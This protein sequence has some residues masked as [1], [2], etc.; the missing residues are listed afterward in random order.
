[1]TKIDDD[2]EMLF[3]ESVR[4]HRRLLTGF[5]GHKDVSIEKWEEAQNPK[6]VA[7]SLNGE[8]T[9]YSRLAEFLEICHDHGGSTFLVT[10]GSLPRTIE[11]LDTLPTQLY[12]SVDAPNKEIFNKLQAKVQQQFLGTVGENT[13]AVAFLGYSNRLSTYPHQEPF[14]WIPRRLRAT[15]QHG[16]PRF[17][18][19]QRIRLRRSFAE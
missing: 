12:V 14:T 5:K 15:G 1:M 13:R 16:R 19:S 4:A 6:H 9:L 18:R 10:N 8:P 7:I 17:H 3:Y 2:P 11:R